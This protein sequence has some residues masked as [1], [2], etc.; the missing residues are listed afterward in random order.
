MTDPDLSIVQRVLQGEKRAYAVLVQRY[1]R[2][3]YTAALRIVGDPDE[4]RDAAQAALVKAYENLDRF[5]QGHRFFSWLYRIAVN[6]ALDRLARR[7]RLR[8]LDDDHRSERPGPDEEL[9]GAERTRILHRGLSRLPVEQRVI[10]ILK[11]LLFLSYQ[12]IGQVL[13]IEV[14]LVKSRL[15]SARQA[16]KKELAREGYP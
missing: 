13:E 14:P 10:I 9:A 15:Y 8:E 5:D 7:K 4:A 3:I 12:E 6:E 2:P 11:H 1:D 16:L